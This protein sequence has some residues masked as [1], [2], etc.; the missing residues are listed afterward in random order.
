MVEE[1]VHVNE[2]GHKCRRIPKRGQNLAPL[3][4]Q[5]AAAEFSKKYR[6]LRGTGHLYRPAQ[7]HEPRKPPLRH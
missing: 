4:A 3:T 6:L 7:G 2:K 5:S 1:C